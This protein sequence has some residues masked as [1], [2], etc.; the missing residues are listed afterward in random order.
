MNTLHK[1]V[2]LFTCGT[3]HLQTCAVAAVHSNVLLLLRPG[4]LVALCSDCLRQFPLCLLLDI[5]Y[6]FIKFAHACT[7]FI[8][9]PTALNADRRGVATQN[10]NTQGAFIAESQLYSKCTV[11]VR[12]HAPLYTHTVG[13]HVTAVELLTNWT[14]TQ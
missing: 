9:M 1:N 8:S 3:M 11:Y 6:L 4:R 14:M 13:G 5:V 2:Y 12:M 10:S 7:C